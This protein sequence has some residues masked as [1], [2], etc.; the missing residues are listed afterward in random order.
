[1]SELTGI[2]D[3]Y[4]ANS[5]KSHFN[6]VENQFLFTPSTKLFR[7]FC[8]QIIERFGSS[9]A[10]LLKNTSYNLQDKVIKGKV[11]SIV[12]VFPTDSVAEEIPQDKLERKCTTVSKLI[13]V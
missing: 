10:F 11:N 4:L 1:M 8:Q 5:S 12:P 13:S 3:L 7:D 6:P 9:G 2:P